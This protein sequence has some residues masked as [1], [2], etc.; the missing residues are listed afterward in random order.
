MEEIKIIYQSLDDRLNFMKGLVRISRADSKFTSE[1]E[2]FFINAANSFELPKNSIEELKIALN[3]KNLQLPVFLS[4]KKQKLFF[5]K[6][7]LQ[8]C[9]IDG[10]VT[11]SERIE[12]NQLGIDLSVNQREIDAIEAWVMEGMDWVK[13]GSQLLQE[14]EDL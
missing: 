9:Y 6:E 14:L 7:A 5:F 4:S 10:E 8:I 13:R 3:D 1:E 2:S 11:D 12:I